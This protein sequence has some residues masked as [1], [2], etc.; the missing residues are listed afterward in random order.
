MF[1]LIAW[2][3]LVSATSLRAV[4]A[5]NFL[6]QSDEWVKSPA[7]IA[8]VERIVSW[9]RPE[10]GWEKEYD[11]ATPHEPGKPFGNWGDVG[12]ID[13]NLTYS[14]IRLIA[15][16]A[17]LNNRDDFRSATAKGID[18]LLAMQYPNGGFPQRFPLPNNYGREITFNDNAMVN[19]LRTLNDVNNDRDGAFGFVDDARRAK[20]RDAF[21]RGIQ[22]I[23]KSQ[24]RAGETLSAWPQQM[25][26]QTLAPAPARAY[27]LI[28]ISGSESAAI[29]I[30]LMDQ[31]NPSPE[32][33]RAVHAAA[34]WYEKSKLTGIRTQRTGND[35]VV[36][37]DAAAPPLWARFYEID[38]NRAF[39]C[40]RDGIKKY[41]L[42]E[43]EQERRRGY[44]WYGNWGASVLARYAEWKTAYPPK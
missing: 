44:A 28:S 15:R 22:C 38:T 18:F 1:L 26:A 6:R 10:G 24:I 27:E 41:T 5:E 36:V 7:G 19:V 13:N 25:D 39:F 40:G 12:T 3:V 2:T 14:E 35:V 20:A 21:E 4:T 30:L 43:I 33:Q 16:S 37:Q 29:A 34:A 32:I 23:L 17:K 8:T 9:Q 31:K 11:A 42:A